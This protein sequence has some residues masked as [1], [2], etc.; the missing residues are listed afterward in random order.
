MLKYIATGC[1]CAVLCAC[2]SAPKE[3]VSAPKEPA[4]V[5]LPAAPPASEPNG[6]AGMEASAVRVAFGPPVFV[7]KEGAAEM[8]R[9]DNPSC[10]AFFF[11]YPNGASLAVRHVETIPRGR[12]TTADAACLERL[13]LR[14]N[15][16]VS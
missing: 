16:P 15:A 5:V 3:T 10:K 7:R 8:W 14:A 6:L 4:K 1:L 11:L 2:A 13:R 12:D 9:Y